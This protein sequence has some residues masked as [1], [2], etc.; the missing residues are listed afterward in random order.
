MG[1]RVSDTRWQRADDAVNVSLDRCDVCAANACYKQRRT[2]TMN[3]KYQAQ[4]EQNNQET[5]SQREQLY[6]GYTTSG[7]LSAATMASSR[8]YER[9][10]C[11][12]NTR[13]RESAERMRVNQRYLLCITPSEL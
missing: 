12:I 4:S 10:M 5:V 9:A 6:K 7:R 11:S 1:V 8:R 3:V 13:A 2:A